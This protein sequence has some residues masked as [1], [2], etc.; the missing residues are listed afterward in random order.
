M[1]PMS[2]IRRGNTLHDRVSAHLTDT[3]IIIFALPKV[4]SFKQI[5]CN[6]KHMNHMETYT[7]YFKNMPGVYFE[8]QAHKCI[9]LIQ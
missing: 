2:F 5:F 3:L 4:M 8:R 9:Y 6:T 1:Y 7:V